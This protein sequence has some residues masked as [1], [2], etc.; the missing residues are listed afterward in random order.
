MSVCKNSSPMSLKDSEGVRDY[1]LRLN[2]EVQN[3]FSSINPDDNFSL[4]TLN[5]YLENEKQ[6]ALFEL[7]AENL[8]SLI[9]DKT[10]ESTSLINQNAHEISLC[11]KQGEL[12]SKLNLE[13]YNITISGERLNINMNNF[14]VV[15][16]GDAYV[17]GTL[18][19]TA[20]NIAGWSIS[21][22]NGHHYWTGNQDTNISV[23]SIEAESGT[24]DSVEAWGS[25]DINA[26]FMGNFGTIYN[27]EAVFDGGFTAS[28]IE[29]DS[30]MT[31]TGNVIVKKSY[32]DEG[33]PRYDP[34]VHPDEYDDFNYAPK[35]NGDDDE[36]LSH[37]DWQDEHFGFIV[38]GT[39][40]CYRYYSKLAGMTVSDRRL[41]K[42]IENVKKSDALDLLNTLVPRRY[43][44]IKG[45]E[46]TQGFIAQ[47]TPE[48]YRVTLKNGK[49]GLKYNSIMCTL[50]EVIKTMTERLKQYE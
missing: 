26:T 16:N 18:T 32:R 1:I 24:A 5:H 17:R 37:Y 42:D 3:I 22:S 31:V 6:A 20:G 43:T 39:I 10:N 25:V 19:A 28:C 36:T 34:V 4:D 49:L 44:L 2:K 41:K 33:E 12:V 13:P 15:P 8:T 11:V 50:D 46:R 38:N 21:T 48:K 47:E 23:N 14:K 27:D 40:E 7:T 29:G 30:T 45:G 35:S 9:T